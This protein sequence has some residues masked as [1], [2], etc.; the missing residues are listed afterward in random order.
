MRVVHVLT[1]RSSPSNP[2][3]YAI[4]EKQLYSS[5][6]FETALDLTFCVRDITDAKQPGFYLI[7]VMGSDQAGLTGA[8]KGSMVRGGCCWP[9][10]VE[11]P[12][13]THNCQEHTGDKVARLNIQKRR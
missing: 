11:S 7:M 13:Q 5:H 8:T 10:S 3:S 9:L 4:P 6:Y 12:N 1:M 2:T